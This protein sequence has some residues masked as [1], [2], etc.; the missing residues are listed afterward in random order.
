MAKRGTTKAVNG[1]M[2]RQLIE[3]SPWGPRAVAKHAKV[4]IQTVYQMQKGERVEVDLIAKVA[5]VLGKEWKELVEGGESTSLVKIDEPKPPALSVTLA[6]PDSDVADA[7]L[8]SL[9]C[10]TF[11]KA[12]AEYDLVKK[13]KF[14]NWII[15]AEVP[16][17][18][19]EEGDTLI[20]YLVPGHNKY[21]HEVFVYALSA[22]SQ[23]DR[24]MDELETGKILESAMIIAMGIGK[25]TAE[26]RSKIREIYGVDL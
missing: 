9:F 4:G 21:G 5:A 19:L 26:A 24:F 12:L 11:Q 23:H 22:R 14:N 17:I 15:F 7:E 3:T 2:V 20:V 25:P 13:Y 18:D 10:G 16:P 8:V 1:E 6:M